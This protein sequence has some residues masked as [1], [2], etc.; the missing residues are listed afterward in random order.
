MSQYIDINSIDGICTVTINRPD[1]KNALTR[2]MYEA[3]A[4]LI[5]QARDDADK[6][7]VVIIG[8]GSDFCAGN[9]MSD[10]LT[11][12]KDNYR[13]SAV[14]L[15]LELTDTHVPI[16]AAV[17]GRAIG[18]GTTLLTH[19]DFVYA[20]PDAVFSLP[21]INLGVVPEA[22][23]SQTL[24]L[25]AGYRKAA[26]LFMLGEAFDAQT[27]CDIGLVSALSNLGEAHT[28]AQA[29]AAKLATKP[30]QALRH[31]KALMRRS[32]EGLRERVLAEIEIFKECLFSDS[33]REIMSAF[34][35]KRAP[36]P[37]KID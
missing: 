19:C 23:S 11:R 15:L 24:V 8:A 18:I 2:D 20:E 36:D 21:F 34:M 12:D 33:A 13:S 10:F 31:T 3:M 37:N 26:E 9:D 6:R 17:Q 28:M 27:A 4:G 32:P 5:A 1:K 16:V 14:S 30:R 25:Q 29:T 22:A 35:E 7:V